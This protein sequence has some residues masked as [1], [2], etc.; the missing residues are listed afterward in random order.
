MT[1]FFLS[2]ST[3]TAIGCLVYGIHKVKEELVHG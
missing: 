2:I 1:F 3:L